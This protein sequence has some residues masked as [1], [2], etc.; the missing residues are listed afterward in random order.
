LPADKRELLVLSRWQELPYDEI[1]G[2]LHC[3]PGTVKTRVFRAMQ[4]LA[5]MF[6]R[7]SERRA[8]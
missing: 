2:I 3:E 4:Q 1:A 8:S 7:L 6:F 5:E